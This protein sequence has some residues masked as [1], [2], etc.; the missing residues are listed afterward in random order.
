[1]NILYISQYFPPEIGATQV[2]AKEN[3]LHLRELGHSVTVLT[4][5]PNHPQGIIH[6]RY[7]RK[8]MVREKWQ[9]IPVLRVWVFTRPEKNFLTR[10]LFY[11]SFMLMGMAAGSIF[12]RQRYQIVY[13]TSPPIFVG[14][15]GWYLSR[16][17]GGKF[18]FEVRDLW[19][20][21]AV[22]LGELT[23][24]AVIKMAERLESFYYRKA[25]LNVTVTRGIFDYIAAQVGEKKLFFLPNG[26]NTRIFSPDFP[27]PTRLRERFKDK[28]VVSYTGIIGL[29]HGVE[30]VIRAAERLQSVPDILFLIIGDGVKKNEVVQLA[31]ERGLQNVIFMDAMQEEELTPYILIS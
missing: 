6:P 8:L 19:P 3:V 1:M 17:R 25:V 20:K 5:M 10:I 31:N 27:V 22:D 2:R 16:L 4:E 24:K 7:R 15:V 30:T 23:N 26:A 21:S 29:I 11:L 14:L 13:A 28:F 18:I 9:G 12:L